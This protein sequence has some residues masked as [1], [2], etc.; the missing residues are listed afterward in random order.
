[1]AGSHLP[2]IVMLCTASILCRFP[3]ATVLGSGN[4]VVRRLKCFQCGAAGVIDAF[5]PELAAPP[6]FDSVHDSASAF[7]AGGTKFLH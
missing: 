3:A 7:D 1:M 2:A 6:F 5:E 4:G